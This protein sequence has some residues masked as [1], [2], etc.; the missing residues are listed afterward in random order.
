MEFQYVSSKMIS[1]NIHQYIIYHKIERKQSAKL[2]KKVKI[3][4]FR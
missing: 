4:I 3:L 2:N 1:R